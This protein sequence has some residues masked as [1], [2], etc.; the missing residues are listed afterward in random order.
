MAGGQAV[1]EIA[2]LAP[3]GQGFVHKG[4]EPVIVSRLKQVKHLVDDD[5]FEALA[6]LLRQ[7]GIETDALGSRAAAAPLS[8]HSLDEKALHLHLHAPLPKGDEL[9]QGCFQLV[10]V[11]CLD[12][13]SPLAGRQSGPHPEEQLAL[14][15]LDGGHS[16]GLV[17]PHQVTRTPDIVA[18]PA[19]VLPR[20]FALLC[21]EF[22]LLLLNPCKF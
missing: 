9:W 22:P 15:R 5:V 8:L 3:V 2:G 12:D 7:F 14:S 16:F 18:F 17:D 20:S 21:P 1:E 4:D 6:G 11:P 10:S 13:L 19:D